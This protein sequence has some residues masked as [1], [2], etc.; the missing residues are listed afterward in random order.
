MREENSFEEICRFVLD[1]C[2]KGGG[3]RNSYA[4]F[5]FSESE[6]LISWKKSP[7]ITRVKNSLFYYYFKKSDFL[8]MHHGCNKLSWHVTSAYVS[9][10]SP[11]LKRSMKF[12]QHGGVYERM[13]GTLN[14]NEIAAF[15]SAVW[16][17]LRI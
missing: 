1:K 14:W 17:L 10:N 8:V 11:T 6:L 5:D 7:E 12:W 13:C 2:E 4:F 15:D 9:A 16:K 3:E